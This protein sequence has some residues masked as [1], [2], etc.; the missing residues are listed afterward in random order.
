MW[1]APGEPPFLPGHVI[2]TRSASSAGGQKPCSNI[3]SLAW[4]RRADPPGQACPSVRS[5]CLLRLPG[6]LRRRSEGLFQ[7]R[8]DCVCNCGD[9]RLVPPPFVNVVEHLLIE[10]DQLLDGI[11]LGSPSRHV[12]IARNL[13]YTLLTTSI[14]RI[15]L[16]S[17]PSKR[18]NLLPGSH[19][20]QGD[21]FHGT[22]C[23]QD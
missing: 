23:R 11:E 14:F 3:R 7:Q 22:G 5:I 13:R 20:N 2:A 18:L 17:E 12:I 6:A 10:P 19:P 15:S 21:R 4:R 9:W 8:S 16:N 1:V